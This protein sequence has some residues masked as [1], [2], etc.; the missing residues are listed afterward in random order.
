ML[1]ECF[2]NELCVPHKEGSSIKRIYTLSLKRL[3]RKRIS[4][5]GARGSFYR[6]IVNLFVD[7][8]EREQHR[9]I[10]IEALLNTLNNAVNALNEVHDEL[11]K[12]PASMLFE[13]EQ[14]WHIVLANYADKY[15]QIS[16]DVLAK[17]IDNIG[18]APTTEQDEKNE[19]EFI[20]VRRYHIGANKQQETG[21]QH[22]GDVIVNI[23]QYSNTKEYKQIQIYKFL[24]EDWGIRV[25]DMIKTLEEI[26]D[27]K[28]KERKMNQKERRNYTNPDISNVESGRRE[29][30][31][32]ELK[33]IVEALW[34]EVV[35]LVGIADDNNNEQGM[36]PLG[37]FEEV[38]NKCA[39]NEKLLELIEIFYA[40]G[41]KGF[42]IRRQIE[43]FIIEE[44]DMV[45]RNKSKDE[46]KERLLEG[47]LV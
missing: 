16:H 40:N 27:E 41:K 2:Y 39:E 46:E 33:N 7:L 47:M 35:K 3:S 23:R 21:I 28:I 30:T 6:K 42:P 5:K 1:A 19:Q 20:D 17:Y 38:I 25:K 22:K 45:K 10:D 9:K 43:E 24:R 29:V 12:T 37:K 44:L 31:Q 14:K 4:S 34:V 15:E 32:E 18:M 26:Q 36:V 11:Y 13:R 8:R